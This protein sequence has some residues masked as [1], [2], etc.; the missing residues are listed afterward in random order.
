M[1]SM[2]SDHGKEYNTAKG[3]NTATE[4][5]E[6]RDTLFNKKNQTKWKEFKVKNTNLEQKKSTKDHYH[7]LMIK[8]VLNDGSHKLAYF[9]KDKDSQIW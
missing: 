5:N 7:V 2:L 8:D 9:H 3:V 4:F 6:S 1:H